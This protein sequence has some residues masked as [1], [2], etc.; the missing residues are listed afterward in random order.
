MHIDM[1]E[2]KRTY[3]YH[4]YFFWYADQLHLEIK[5]IHQGIRLSKVEEDMK[6]IVA[7]QEFTIKY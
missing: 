4:A 5:V 2:Y 1:I 3:M 7:Q 6:A